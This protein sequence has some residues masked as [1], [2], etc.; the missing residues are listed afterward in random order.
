[1]ERYKE[2]K[3]LKRYS[4]RWREITE[5]SNKTKQTKERNVTVEDGE[6]P[7]KNDNMKF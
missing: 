3:T 1:M 5:L 4:I 7:E 6:K 2:V